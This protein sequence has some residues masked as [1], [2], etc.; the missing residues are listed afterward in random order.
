MQRMDHALG[1]LVRLA[2]E[3]LGGAGPAF[4]K[5]LDRLNRA[6]CSAQSK[7]AGDSRLGGA[8][9]NPRRRTGR[10]CP[11][12]GSSAFYQRQADADKNFPSSREFFFHF[13]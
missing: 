7:R 3:Q 8:H 5:R 11:E 9:G 2:R 4:D 13:G 6:C 1:V 12:H 10:D